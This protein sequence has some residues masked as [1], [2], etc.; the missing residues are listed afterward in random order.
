MVCIL[1]TPCN[2]IFI[3]IFMKIYCGVKATD[4]TITEIIYDHY[5]TNNANFYLFSF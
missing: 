3:P 4:L 2:M 1:Y 5:I